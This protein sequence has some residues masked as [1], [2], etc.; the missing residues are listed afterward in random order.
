[1]RDYFFEFGFKFG[2]LAIMFA[3]AA[4]LWGLLI[5]ALIDFIKGN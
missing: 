1:M 2:L 5:K 3:F 4:M